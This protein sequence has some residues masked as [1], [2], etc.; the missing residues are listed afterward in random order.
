M[1]HQG[2]A[3]PERCA[4]TTKAPKV[5]VNIYYESLNLLTRNYFTR[6]IGP[7]Y[8]VIEDMVQINLIPYGNTQLDTSD[9]SNNFTCG[10]GVDQCI[11]NRIQV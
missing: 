10:A 4:N 2:E 1:F 7:F 6:Q 11:A 5:K 9:G 3:K 8:H